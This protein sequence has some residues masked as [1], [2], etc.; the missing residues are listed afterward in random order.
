MVFR[1]EYYENVISKHHLKK[2]DWRQ[3]AVAS[4]MSGLDKKYVSVASVRQVDEDTVEIIKRRDAKPS[5]L[6]KLGFDQFGV[7]E[8]VTI[9]RK[10]FSVSVDRIDRNWR[11]P[12]P[13]LG[14]RD[15]FYVDKQDVE[16]LQEGSAK[17]LRLTFVRHN[18]W[19]NK[20]LKCPTVTLSNFSA[21]SYKKAFL[22][23]TI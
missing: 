4:F 14:Q 16:A 3:G 6:Y 11:I 15:L 19:L 13:F 5:L 7:F 9:N 1:F 23:E 2:V 21:W 10:D 20:L 12:E 22:K 17:G 18:F 8:R